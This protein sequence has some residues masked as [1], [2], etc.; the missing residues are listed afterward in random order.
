[1]ACDLDPQFNFLYGYFTCNLPDNTN[2]VDITVHTLKGMHTVRKDHNTQTSTCSLWGT[3]VRPFPFLRKK[4]E[5]YMRECQAIINPLSLTREYP[6][7]PN[8]LPSAKKCRTTP[9]KRSHLETK[10]KI[11][12][13][14]SQ[15]KQIRDALKGSMP[16]NPIIIQPTASVALPIQ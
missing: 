3:L 8:S 13:Y 5:D 14:I 4:M 1:M 11:K 12:K 16:Q 6:N 9:N 2:D 7:R 15:E 10:C